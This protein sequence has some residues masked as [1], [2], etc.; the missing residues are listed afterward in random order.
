MLKTSHIELYGIIAIKSLL[1]LLFYTLGNEL[2][3]SLLF[4]VKSF[5]L[6]LQN[7]V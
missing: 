6:P 2:F 3:M 1:I 4:A 5:V 7:M